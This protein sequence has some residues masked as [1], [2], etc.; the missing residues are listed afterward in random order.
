[1]LWIDIPA[2]R[3]DGTAKA[4]DAIQVR[5]TLLWGRAVS[6]LCAD[7]GP[8]IL[9][10]CVRTVGIVCCNEQSSDSGCVFF[11]YVLQGLESSS[12]WVTGIAV[13]A[14]GTRLPADAYCELTL[15]DSEGT[16]ATYKKT[17][18]GSKL[19]WA[20]VLE[21]EMRNFNKTQ[22]AGAVSLEV[23]SNYRIDGYAFMNANMTFGAGE[24]GRACGTACNP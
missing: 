19:V 12:G 22:A 8:P 3:L 24:M 5:T 17:D 6:G 13:S 1:M 14:R 4:G 23:K 16:V 2:M 7:C 11:P 10:E 18:M 20:F 15:K 21:R 9:C